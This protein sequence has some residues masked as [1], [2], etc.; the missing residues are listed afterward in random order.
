MPFPLFVN[1]SVSYAVMVVWLESFE[2]HSRF[3]TEGLLPYTDTTGLAHQG[4]G[5]SQ[6]GA[7][8]LLI[9]VTPL[10]SGLFRLKVLFLSTKQIHSFLIL[11]YYLKFPFYLSIYIRH[12][13]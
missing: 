2:D 13:S 9:F 8:V 12:N 4:A 6:R 10:Q 7:D 5:P 11:P 3:P 1:T